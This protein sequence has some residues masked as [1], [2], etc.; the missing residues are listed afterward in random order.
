MDAAP[1]SSPFIILA[2]PRSRTAWLT[3]FLSYEGRKV[4]HDLAIDCDGVDSFTSTLSGYLGTVETG[5][6]VAAP[7]LRRAIPESRMIVVRRNVADVL[8][9]LAKFGITGVEKEMEARAAA[10][11]QLS[12]RR[13]VTTI[14]YEALADV[15]VCAWIFQS[16]LGV[17]FDKG[18]W[19]ALADTNVQVDVA[20]E[21][22]RV[23]ANAAAIQKFKA[24]VR[25]RLPKEEP[26]SGPIVAMEPFGSIWPECVELG[27]R[28]WEEVETET[29]PRR[30]FNLNRALLSHASVQGSLRIAT[31]RINGKLVGYLFWT[32][33]HDPE[34][35]GLLIADQGAWF[36]SPDA[37]P[38]TAL[39]LYERSIA[40]L[41]AAGVR[42]IYPHHRTTGRGAGLGKFF[43]RRG[44]VPEKQVYSLWIG[45]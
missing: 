10:L 39:R 24:E 34:S 38:R 26:Y 20:K 13:G 44:A 29:D 4:G 40:E 19:A 28:H 35:A 41:R 5:L 2:L 43:A 45:E 3:R 8:A 15:S 21:L 18:W 22:A 31:A 32:V 37:P 27:K 14:R 25:R 33:M 36:V 17:S 1:K 7:V 30:T 16:C 12:R 42:L 23:E 11:D 6:A 9:S